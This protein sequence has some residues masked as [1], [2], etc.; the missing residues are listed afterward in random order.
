MTDE[1]IS[2]ESARGRVRRL[3]IN[4][5]IADGFRKR[6]ETDA[7]KHHADLDRIADSLTY[8]TDEGLQRLRLVLATKGEGSAKHFWPCYASVMGLAELVESRPL[9]ELPELLRWFVSAAGRA[10]LDAGRH[11]VEYEFWK[12]HKRPPF[13]QERARID[14]QAA[15]WNSKVERLREFLA[16]RPGRVWPQ[17]RQ[18]LDWYEAQDRYVRGLINGGEA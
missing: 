3:L 16:D 1:R 14:A 13:P 10:A 12:K 6:R 15:E 7:D 11:V 18:W 17:D 9:E 4:P 2:T 8:M 5:L